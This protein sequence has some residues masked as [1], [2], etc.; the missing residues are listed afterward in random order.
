M[1]VED[2]AWEAEM[3]ALAAGRLPPEPPRGRRRGF[4]QEQSAVVERQQEESARK[5]QEE[6]ERHALQDKTVA[7][8]KLE[9]IGRAS[10]RERVF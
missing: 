8:P 3:D 2:A 5:E 1:A 10:C 9:E 4:E 7:R 6:L